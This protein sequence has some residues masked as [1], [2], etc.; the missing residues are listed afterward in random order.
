MTEKRERGPTGE[1]EDGGDRARGLGSD[2]DELSLAIRT[3]AGWAAKNDAAIS[4]D[5]EGG[6]SVWRKDCVGG[7][8]K[9]AF[10]QR[11]REI[12]RRK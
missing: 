7:N 3:G 1:A 11:E 2:I 6:K 8:E 5:R 10:V 12:S 9:P 4:L